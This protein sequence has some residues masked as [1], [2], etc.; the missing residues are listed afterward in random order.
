MGDGVDFSTD[1]IDW[2]YV[3]VADATGC[4]A[5]VRAIRVRLT[6]TQAAASGF[7]LRYRVIVR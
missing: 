6:G 7:R 4:D 2:T 3:P 5:N 1:G